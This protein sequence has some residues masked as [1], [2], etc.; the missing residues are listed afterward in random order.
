M[1]TQVFDIAVD[2]QLVPSMT[3]ANMFKH[4]HD[5]HQFINIL[6]LPEGNIIECGTV[7]A[8]GCHYLTNCPNWQLVDHRPQYIGYCSQ[9]LSL[10]DINNRVQA[11][12]LEDKPQLANLFTAQ[13]IILHCD[14][15]GELND[16]QLDTVAFAISQCHQQQTII[17]M[18]FDD[19]RAQK[20]GYQTQSKQQRYYRLPAWIRQVTAHMH[21]GVDKKHFVDGT[22][23]IIFSGAQPCQP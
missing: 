17:L 16:K 5:Y 7:L 11:L 19:N 22:S 1:L 9:V 15:L 2:N 8:N 18:G 3:M 6:G 10:L 12:S 20:T 21:M 14:W 13:T 4:D 23:A